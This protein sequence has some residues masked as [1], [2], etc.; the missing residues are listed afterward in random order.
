MGTS[1]V[2]KIQSIIKPEWCYVGSATYAKNRWNLHLADLRKN[3]HHS[4]QLQR[5][6]NEYG[7]KDLVFIVLEPCFPEFL[8]IR[9]QYYL[10]KL[11]PY[12][13]CSPTAGSSLGIKRSD[14]F[15]LK[16]SRSCKGH[17]LSEETKQRMKDNWLMKRL[18]KQLN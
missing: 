17:K 13:N 16:V 5:H 3:K 2:Y 8:R 12:F 6:Y 10:D 4:P 18:K 9:E 14:E 15:K 11:K 1:C 7:K